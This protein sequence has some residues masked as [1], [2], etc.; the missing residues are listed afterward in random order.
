MLHV[1]HK[2]GEK[3]DNSSENLIALCADCHR[4]EPFHGHMFVKHEDTQKINQLRNDQDVY[5]KC[6]WESVSMKV[7]PSLMGVIEHCKFKGYTAPEVAYTLA[8]NHGRQSVVLELAWP[9]RRFG[10]VL[11]NAREVEG[12]QV[13]SLSDALAFFGKRKAAKRKY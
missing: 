8:G 11:R 1:H 5:A 3:S 12:W 9:K 2:S 6:D 4:K 10:I 7:D 13:L